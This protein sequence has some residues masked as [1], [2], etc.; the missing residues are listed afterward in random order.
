M[1]VEHRSRRGQTWYLHAKATATGKSSYFFSMDA[2]G[3]LVQAVPDG[4]E[5]Y[6]NVNSQVFLRKKTAQVIQ[7][8][9]LAIVEDA[10]RRH[11]DPWRHWVEVKKDVIVVYHAGEMNGIDGML[12]S[13]GRSPLTETDRRRFATYT[14]VLR[15]TLIDR[16]VRG[17][18]AE[19]FCFRGSIDDWIPIGGPAP[20]AAHV[21]QFVR[22]LGRE[23]FY[24]LF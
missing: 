9:E 21:R 12:A 18:V 6:E 5:I 4:Y 16:K 15:F 8:K 14:A 19:R 24:E 22:H 7:P 1:S 20:L 11:E 3:Q 17:F 10:L 23:S 13:F 2:D